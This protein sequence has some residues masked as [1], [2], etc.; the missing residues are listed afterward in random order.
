MLLQLPQ[1]FNKYS[2]LNSLSF[3]PQTWG[4]GGIEPCPPPPPPPPPSPMVILES[5]KPSHNVLYILEALSLY[6][7]YCRQRPQRC[8]ESFMGGQHAGHCADH[9]L[10][11][12]RYS[13]TE[14]LRNRVTVTSTSDI[15]LR[16]KGSFNINHA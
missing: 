15:W 7:L 12:P 1:L 3:T 13:C 16:K 8:I 4:P 10:H 14:R 9:V 5:T 6:P 11:P 2:N